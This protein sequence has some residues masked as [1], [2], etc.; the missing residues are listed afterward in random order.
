MSRSRLSKPVVAGLAAGCLFM[1]LAVD[2][3]AQTAVKKKSAIRPVEASDDDVNAPEVK[4]R[5][6]PATKGTAGGTGQP[7]DKTPSA[8]KNLPG[9][10]PSGKTPE[11]KALPQGKI[12]G[13]AKTSPDIKTQKKGIPDDARRPRPEAEPMRVE[14]ISPELEQIL[15]D[16]EEYSSRVKKLTGTF[17]RAKIDRTFGVELWA[18]GK[19]A[20]QAPDKG[21][22]AFAGTKLRKDD[23]SEIENADGSLFELK[24]DETEN[25]VCTGAE[26]L[27]IY[28]AVKQYERVA[29]PPESQGD[30]IIEGPLPFL[31]GMKAEQAKRRY[32]FKLNKPHS[33]YKDAINL[34]VLPREK[35]DS[36]HWV[37]AR[38]ILSRQNYLPIVVKL[39]EPGENT[40]TVHIFTDLQVNGKKGIAEFFGKREPFNPDL[41]RHKLVLNQK[42]GPPASQPRDIPDLGA[43]PTTPGGTKGKAIT[44]DRADR[45]AP[46]SA[47]ASGGMKKPGSVQK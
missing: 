39:T 29:I 2:L 27:K 5:T 11:S 35:R 42:D 41:S 14:K 4:P 10:T 40:E 31:F 37:K 21:A 32:I 8:K 33:N 25:W 7:A 28:D 12:S 16:W 47:D 30:N 34:S 38:V 9:N 20:Y 46:R 13:A 15:K 3:P 44:G 22:Y 36:D 19:F 26:V 45:A 23:A 1:T 43:R 6:R 18:D 17:K 24:S